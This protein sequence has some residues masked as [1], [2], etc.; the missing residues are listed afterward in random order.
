MDI[1][2]LDNG[3]YPDVARR[4]AK[5]GASVG[6]FSTWG[7][8]FPRSQEQAPAIGIPH[9]ERV[10]DPIQALAAHPGLVVVADLYL[11]DYEFLA[12]QLEIPTVGANTGTQL[13][14]DRWRLKEVLSNA[15]L[16]VIQ[17]VEIE[18]LENV[19][20]YLQEHPDTYVKVSTFRGDME[21][22]KAADWL[23][24]YHDLAARLGPFGSRMR[25]IVEDAIPDA[26][27]VGLDGYYCGST[28]LEP[29]VVGVETKDATYWGAVVDSIERLPREVRK[30]VNVIGGIFKQC[31]YRGFFSNEMRI[32]PDGRTFFTDATCRVPSPPGG[33][34]MGACRNFAEVIRGLGKGVAVA[35]DY[36]GRWLTEIVLKSDWVADRFLEVKV[37]SLE[38]YTFHNYC[39]L[40]DRVWVIPHDSQMSEFGS[41]LGWGDDLESAIRAATDAAEEVNAN[42]LTWEK[43]EPRE[44][45]ECRQELREVGF[46]L[47]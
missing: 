19:R 1:L 4:L 18:G 23:V 40:D 15:G 2:V 6:Y 9:V 41:A 21:T 37:P 36:A 47:E 26:I 38:L 28:W 7:N 11:D 12:R 32:L 45:L 39:V 8:S 46:D 3:L 30:I 34:M 31:G 27:E 35:P 24:E 13:E 17:S 10:N 29:F 22:R 25:F 44:A 20:A 42:R 5:S 33:V 43:P 16:E 14:T